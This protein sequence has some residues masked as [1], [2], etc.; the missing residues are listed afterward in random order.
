MGD[1]DGLPSRAMTCE[2]WL[3]MLALTARTRHSDTALA[4]QLHLMSRLLQRCLLSLHNHVTICTQRRLL[5]GS[6]VARFAREGDGHPCPTR[7]PE[8]T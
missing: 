4:T 8:V 1:M 2:S 5:R 7:V 6:Y 3:R